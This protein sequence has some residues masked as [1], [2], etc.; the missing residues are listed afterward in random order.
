MLLDDWTCIVAWMSIMLYSMTAF[1]MIH[2]GL[3]HHVSEVSSDDF[4]EIMKWLYASSIVYIPAAYVTKVT[5]LLLVARVFAVMERVV[6][7]IHIFIIALFFA[8]LP[9]Q[10][11]KII[12]CNPIPS[13]W[14]PDI[15]GHCLDQRKM[16]VSDLCLA[17][18]TDV[19]ILVLPI[20]LTWSLSFPWKKKLKI[21]LLLGAG[22]AA[23]AVTTYRLYLVIMFLGSTD[24]TYDFAWLAL[25]TLLEMSLGLVCTCFPAVNVLV[26]R[27][28]GNRKSSHSS[29][30]QRRE[31][32][33]RPRTRRSQ[34]PPDRRVAAAGDDGSKQHSDILTLWTSISGRSIVKTHSDSRRGDKMTTTTSFFSTRHFGSFATG[35]RTKGGEKS[36]KHGR[37][38]D[39]DDDDD[40]APTGTCSTSQ[41]TAS[42]I[43]CD[44]SA[45]HKNNNNTNH[46]NYKTEKDH[47]QSSGTPPPLPESPDFDVEA[48][49]STGRPVVLARQFREQV[50]T[51]GGPGCLRPVDAEQGRREGWLAQPPDENSVTGASAVGSSAAAG[52]WYGTAG[53][54]MTWHAQ[55]CQSLRDTTGHDGAGPKRDWI[56]DGT[57][58][59]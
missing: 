32:Q 11:V 3:G 23:T 47:L 8:Y 28:R 46:D 45:S 29:R 57:W 40:A 26:D 12:A 41:H 54:T 9:I 2:Y 59:G 14:D 10:I 49:M 55:W 35:T 13:Y 24:A 43:G 58:R 37:Q 31:H 15:T 48:Q 34:L 17:I 53:S 30:Q 7:G 52:G 44:L 6:K 19:T 5:L 33:H 16:F 38:Y 21:A 4:V 20:P 42:I 36:R 39:D 51:A 22:G 18:I 50:P 1:M 56:W 25:L 27:I